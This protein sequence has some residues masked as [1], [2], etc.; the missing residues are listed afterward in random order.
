MPL[1]G[2]GCVPGSANVMP[3][4][5]PSM[6][7]LFET[8]RLRCRR[9]TATDFD[10]VYAIYSD[11]IAMRF[12]GEGKPISREACEKW[13]QV[14]ETNYQTRGYGMF[15]LEDQASGLVIGCCGLTHPGG[16]ADVEIKYTFLRE[17]WGKGLASEVVPALLRY[18]WQ[19]HGL[20]RV[21]AT[22]DPE[23]TISQKTLAKAGASVVE[24]RLEEDGTTTLVFEWLAPGVA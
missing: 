12:V 19:E 3:R 14:T 6:P 24:H 22:V 7:F 8:P 2:A 10:A 23:N 15:A 20:A 11:P 5:P 4:K 16:Q 21:I 9:W 1:R 13:F 18:G 17:R